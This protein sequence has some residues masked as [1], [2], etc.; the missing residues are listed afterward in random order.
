[1]PN[2]GGAHG[3]VSTT[4]KVTLWELRLGYANLKYYLIRN[5]V[6]KIKH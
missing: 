2:V 3:Q 6:H 4:Q 1:M 5:K